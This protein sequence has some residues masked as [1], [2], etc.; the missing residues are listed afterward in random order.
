MPATPLAAHSTSA[1]ASSCRTMRHCPAPIASR[2]ATSRRL[3]A[4]RASNRFD[5]FRHAITNSITAAPNSSST[6][7]RE[8][9]VSCSRNGIAAASDIHVASPKRTFIDRDSALIS[10]WAAASG[11]PSA[12]RAT[13]CQLCDVRD[14]LVWVSW[15]AVQDRSRQGSRI[16]A[17]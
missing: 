2:N 15:R 17:A 5:T 1:S 10:A 6:V 12:S 4:T 14:R 9:A 11:T 13:A 8:A 3:V 16:R 7:E